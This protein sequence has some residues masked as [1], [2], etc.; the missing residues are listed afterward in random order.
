MKTFNKYLKKS[1]KND[2]E[3]EALYKKELALKKAKQTRN[4]SH[5]KGRN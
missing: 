4:N 5:E 2:P 1:F 3:L